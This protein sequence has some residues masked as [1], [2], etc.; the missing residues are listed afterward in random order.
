M[1]N[2]KGA[3]PILLVV[4]IVLIVGGA[5]FFV[6]KNTITPTA[7]VIMN[8]E[9]D[10]TQ[11]VISEP[12][13]EINQNEVSP[14]VTTTD[15]SCVSNWDCSNWGTCQGKKR[16][17]TCEDLNKCAIPTKTPALTQGCGGGSPVYFPS[18]Y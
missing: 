3:I 16:T 6:I 12:E 17:R 10:N 15:N 14:S 4:A 13:L 18:G 5:S 11:Q 1:I 8:P 9:E 2:R 7:E